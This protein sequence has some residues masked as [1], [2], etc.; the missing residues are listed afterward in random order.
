MWISKMNY[1][2]TISAI[3]LCLCVLCCC[4]KSKNVETEG[5]KLE[6]RILELTLNDSIVVTSTDC[7]TEPLISVY[8]NQAL[9]DTFRVSS[10]GST[11]YLFN[12]KAENIFYLVSVGGSGSYS[13]I[14]KVDIATKTNE[15]LDYI[16]EGF[17]DLEQLD[18][19]FVFFCATKPSYSDSLISYQW[20]DT[21]DLEFNF[22]NSSD[23]IKMS[24]EEWQAKRNS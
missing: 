21:L 19:G 18:D 23:T 24:Y 1:L 20:T 13:M 8:K 12:S 22:L 3:V 16:S 11:I 6:P 7:Y 4:N 15:M 5:Y 17:L 10:N 9:V 2:K 14:T